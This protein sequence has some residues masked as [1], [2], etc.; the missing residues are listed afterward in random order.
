MGFRIF[1]EL[2]SL[3]LPGLPLRDLL[4]GVALLDVLSVV[5]VLPMLDVSSLYR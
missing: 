2:E 4:V 3:F 5:E 1:C